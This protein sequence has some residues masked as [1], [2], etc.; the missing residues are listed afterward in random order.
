MKT[1]LHEN[2]SDFYSGEQDFYNLAAKPDSEPNKQLT[3]SSLFY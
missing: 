1:V 2:I 3:K